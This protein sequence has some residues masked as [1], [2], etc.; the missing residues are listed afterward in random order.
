MA[1]NHIL[2]LFTSL[3]PPLSY[4]TSAASRSAS[5]PSSLHSPLIN[6]TT[7]QRPIVSNDMSALLGALILTLVFLLG[8]PGNIFIIW[9]IRARARRRSITTLLILNLA[10]ADGFLMALTPF[11]VAYLARQSWDF[12]NVGCKLLFYL[13]CA[14]MY[15]SILLMTLM[16]LQRLSLLVGPRWA[17]GLGA[18]STVLRLL[19]ALWLLVLLLSLPPLLFRQQRKISTKLRLV[20]VCEPEHS[21]QELVIHYTFETVMGFVL[22]YGVII[23]S[24]ACI[25]CRLRQTR[26]HRRIRSEKLILV[27]ITTFGLLWLPYHINNMVQVLAKLLPASSP[28]SNSLDKMGRLSRVVT[29]AIAFSSSSANPMLYALAG[30]V[31]LRQEGLGFVARLFEL[32]ALDTG[33]RRVRQASCRPELHLRDREAESSGSP[34]HS[35]ALSPTSALA[36]NSIL[37][38]APTASTKLSNSRQ[39]SQRE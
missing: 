4:P 20:L 11:F 39:K 19:G 9:S 37:N 8:L 38:S 33:T 15:A 24:Y 34:G 36:L 23:C 1:L 18:R 17:R 28:L 25:L 26:F 27:I 16:S 32:M 10:C 12:G 3:S 14:N 6:D 21:P 30:K 13:C 31:H 35:A 5:P 29:S 22:P 7:D 2:P